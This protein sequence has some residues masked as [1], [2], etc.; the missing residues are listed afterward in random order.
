MR[1][2]IIIIIII[3][4]IDLVVL[5]EVSF[6]AAQIGHLIAAYVTHELEIRVER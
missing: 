1:F 2:A 5:V 3:I 6:K 4:Q